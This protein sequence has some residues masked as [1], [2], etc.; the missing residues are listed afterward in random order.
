MKKALKPIVL[1]SI[2]I[3]AFFIIKGVIFYYTFTKVVVKQIDPQLTVLM[4]AGCN[5]A[6]LVS[7]KEDGDGLIIDTKFGK[8]AKKAHEIASKLIKGKITIV[9]THNHYDHIDGNKLY[10]NATVIAGAYSKAEWSSPPSKIP[11]PDILI[12]DKLRLKIGTETVIIKNIKQAH[13]SNDVI[14]YLKNR[15]VLFAGDLIFNKIHPFLNKKSGTDSKLWINALTTM[16]TDYTV[17]KVVPGHGDITDKSGITEMKNYF[18]NIRLA[19]NDDDKLKDL[20]KQYKN[21]FKIPGLTS[22][23][24]TVA[25]IKSE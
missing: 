6:I 4:G 13:S 11:F 10:T 1:I 22:F 21:Y 8:G 25:Y 15:E 18:K 7:D 12:K 5:T 2:I 19:L 14:I 23:R 3:L 24:K 17:K 20:E 16:E 9:N